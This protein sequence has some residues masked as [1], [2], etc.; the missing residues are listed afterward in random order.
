MDSWKDEV[1]EVN[2]VPLLRGGKLADT[3]AENRAGVY[4]A[5]LWNWIHVEMKASY[6]VFKHAH[7]YSLWHKYAL[8]YVNSF[9]LMCQLRMSGV[10]APK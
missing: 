10:Y 8:C 3:M 4:Q 9:S 6:K 2:M 7:T 1:W 5:E